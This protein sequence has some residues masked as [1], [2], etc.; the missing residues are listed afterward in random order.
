[1]SPHKSTLMSMF[2]KLGAKIVGVPSGQSGNCFGDT[3][4]F[5]LKN[6]GLRGYVSHKLFIHSPDEPGLGGLL[7]PDRELTY[8]DLVR[9]QFDPNA[10]VLLALGRL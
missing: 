4:M 1:M 3:L 10:S 2:H 7:R 6:S 8:E 5:R 9:C